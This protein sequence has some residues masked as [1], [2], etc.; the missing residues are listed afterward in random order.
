MGQRARILAQV[1]GF[2]GWKVAD[3]R[4]EDQDGCVF[5][6]NPHFVPPSDAILVLTMK[7]QWASR[8]SRCLTVVPASRRHERGT[9][10]RWRDLPWAGRSVVLE[11]APDRLDCPQCG[12]HAVELVAWA[13]PRQRQ[14]RRQ[15]HHLA[16]DAFSMPLAHVAT[17]YGLSWGTIRRAEAAAIR[18]WD[19]ERPQKDL[20]RVGVDEKWLGRRHKLAHKFVT[21]VSDLDTGEP[22]W[23]GYGRDSS[24][25]AAWFATLTPE[26]KAKIVL[27][28]VDM[29]APYV[30]AIREH[31]PLAHVAI[32]HDPFHVMKRA[33]EAISELRRS[34]FFRAGERMRAVGRGARWLVLT[35]YSRLGEE[36][37]E[38]LRLLFSY[39][40]K[41]ARAYW[42]I[43]QLRQ[44][45]K[46]EDE[47]SLA[48]G[49]MGVLR[50]INKRAN[51][52]M[53][54]LHDALVDRVDQLLALAH[55]RPP[56]GRIE[57]LNGNWEALVRRGR[58]YRDHAYLLHKLRFMTANPV[59]EQR[60]IL[61]FL[62]L[63]LTP[64][65]YA[66]AS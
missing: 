35:A 24:T 47:S 30:K 37:R 28:A 61:R 55:H 29:H 54:K 3:A 49:L 2:R 31:P 1:A 16:L 63:G 18:R 60:G 46:A 40:T 44:A 42:A 64:P 4:W 5:V 41:L 66:K 20:T 39:N 22:V 58:G 53:R 51:V 65:V 25:L 26:Q 9:R 10:R 45:L 56:T 11:Y 43:E 34:I 48:D 59:R 21:I 17:K 15:Q 52:P 12:S 19:R 33:G 50:R 6:P 38:Q 62:A 32:V 23:I 27:F 14:T 7:R 57:A 36:K 8:C 13:D